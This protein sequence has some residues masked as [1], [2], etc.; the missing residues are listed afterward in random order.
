MNRILLLVVAY[1]IGLSFS[2]AQQEEKAFPSMFYQGVARD[3]NGSVLTNL[4]L[5]IKLS[6]TGQGDT[7]PIYYAEQHKIYTDEEGYF[8]VF[9]QEGKRIEGEFS[10]I[11]WSDANIWLDLEMINPL[12][13]QEKI[14][15]RTELLSV[16]YANF[17]QSAEAITDNIVST[18]RNHS[19]Y[20]TTSGNVKTRP[21]VHFFGT[22]DAQDVTIKTD[23]I[24]RAKFTAEG[25]F[26]V[27]SGVTG[28]Q[29]DPDS[30]PITVEGSRQGIYIKVMGADE[31]KRD[32]N[33]NF[34]TF[35]DDIGV[36][37]RIEGQ[38]LAE[39]EDSAVFKTQ[40]DLYITEG[41]RLAAQIGLVVAEVAALV[42]AGTG[43]AASLIFAFAAAGFYASA[44]A[45]GAQGVALA[46]EAGA[47][48]DNAIEWEA[49][50]KDNIGVAF[51]SGAGDYA[52]YLLRDENT[53]DLLPGEIV[54][55]SAGKVSLNTELSNQLMVISTRPVVLGNMPQDADKK[56][57]EKVAFLG[58][59][60]VR[61]AGKVNKGDY[62]L[63]SGNHDGFG[64]AVAPIDMKLEDYTK[65]VGVA[66]ES[67]EEKPV[68][69]IIM[70]VGLNENDFAPQVESIE[71][72]I[73]NIVDFLEGKAPL[74]RN[75]QAQEE[76][77]ALAEK[78]MTDEAFFAMVDQNEDYLRNLYKNVETE[79][80]KQGLSAAAVPGLEAFLA[81]PIQGL[82]ELR[83]DQQY[84]TQ[85]AQLDRYI[86]QQTGK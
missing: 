41:V 75:G 36:W 44:V 27:Y 72:K 69:T 84:N 86:K 68:N 33:N 20:W 59:V 5:T 19:I 73:D 83:K 13:P 12:N 8:K 9:I 49:N 16:P 54:S 42:L 23:S 21:P 28:D 46:V 53:R 78:I 14:D 25:Q 65:I 37:G 45:A 57:Y 3:A 82:K 71:N 64:V 52:E 56:R 32:S 43:A 50:L 22:R 67:A 24:I 70:G 40:R 85:W 76:S 17:A 29:A 15:T 51:Q 47:L 55:V 74:N 26:E 60:P 2:W 4:P 66:W 31:G 6:F 79:L 35:A 61:V 39:L 30:Y 1:F 63:P 38:N 48:A 10:D 81:D 58:Q 77:P 62:I 80:A 18:L 11:P 7:N 34:V